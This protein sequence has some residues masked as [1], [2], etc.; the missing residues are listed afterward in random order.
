MPILIILILLIVFGPQLWVKYILRKHQKHI[1][2]LDGT[3]SELAHHLVE[4]F[5]L[6]GVEVIKGAEGADYYDPQ[7]KIVSLSPEV[8]EGKSLT[9]VAVAAHEVGHA[10]Q[11]NKGEPVSR[12]RQK[13]LPTAHRIKQLGMMFLMASPFVGLVF[14]IPQMALLTIVIGV[15]TMLVSVLMHAAVLPEE[16]DASFNKAM[17]ILSEGYIKEEELPKVKQ[18]LRACALTYVAA[19]LADILNLWRWMRFMR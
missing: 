15:I 14:R 12:L 9:A 4:R 19:A 2:S 17:P 10:I 5:E 18:I 1:E 6:S 11:F 7:N 13:Y 8:Y 16:F 3:G